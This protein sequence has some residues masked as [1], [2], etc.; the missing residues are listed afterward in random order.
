MTILDVVHNPA[1]ITP[2][3]ACLLIAAGLAAQSSRISL[4]SPGN[5]HDPLNAAVC[6]RRK[7]PAAPEK[8]F[9]PRPRPANP[10][11]IRKLRLRKFWPSKGATH[12]KRCVR[13]R[14]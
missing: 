12:E 1:A 11:P 6:N 4:A 2:Y 14:W 9:P 3:V 5:K 13:Q 8:K 10:R 7:N